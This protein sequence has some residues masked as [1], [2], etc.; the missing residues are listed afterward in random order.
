MTR[1]LHQNMHNRNNI[2][3]DPLH[4]T[5]WM[6]GTEEAIDSLARYRK[7]IWWERSGRPANGCL[8]W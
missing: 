2:S 6:V 5:H 3:V 7:A 8:Y 4:Y 1:M